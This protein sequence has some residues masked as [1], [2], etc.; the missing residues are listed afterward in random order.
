MTS[1]NT[2]DRP[3]DAYPECPECESDVL[4]GATCYDERR[5]F[6][7]GCDNGFVVDDGFIPESCRGGGG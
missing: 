4:V 2:A 7:H 5:Y 1:D 3:S 6:C